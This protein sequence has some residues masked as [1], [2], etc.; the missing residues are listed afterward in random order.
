MSQPKNFPIPHI[1]SDSLKTLRPLFEN[2]PTFKTLGQIF[3][4]AV[5]VDAN[6][7]IRDILWLTRKRKNAASRTEF[8]EV[9][10]AGTVT[11]YAPTFLEQEMTKNLPILASEHGIPL[12]ELTSHWESYRSSIKFIDAGGVDDAYEDPKDAPY[13]KLQAKLGTVILSKDSDIARMGGH[14]ADASLVTRL[15]VYSRHVAVEYSLKAGGTS[16]IIISFAMLSAM[17]KSIATALDQAKRLPKW[18]WFAAL[19]LM[20]A[21]LLHPPTRRSISALI[22]S[23]TG[24]AQEIGKKLLVLIEQLTS[25][26]ER[27]KQEACSALTDIKSILIQV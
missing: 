6:I 17:K 13:I 15:R 19:F 25:E 11:A 18:F 3:K 8:Y 23:L 9:L 4:M 26:H 5:I 21:V 20:I 2:N 27:A 14:V 24:N 22:S 12:E 16:T 7:I 10:L 1:K